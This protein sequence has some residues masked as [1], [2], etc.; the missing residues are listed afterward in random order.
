M[1]DLEL[2]KFWYFRPQRRSQKILPFFMTL[3]PFLYWL[4]RNIQYNCIVSELIY[5]KLRP[6]K[7]FYK[8]KLVA[9]QV[10][11]LKKTS[12]IVPDIL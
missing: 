1:I 12:K 5:E 11:Q 2:C 10:S 8:E 4:Y 9:Y 7:G 6:I 3:D